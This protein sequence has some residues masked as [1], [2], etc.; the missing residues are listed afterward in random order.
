MHAG[1]PYDA[2]GV[3]TAIV[4][5]P[6]APSLGAIYKLVEV[7][8]RRDAR[9]PVGKRSPAKPSYGGAKQVYRFRH[10]DGTLREDIVGRAEAGAETPEVLAG[11]AL[12]VPVM[13]RGKLVRDLP[14][15]HTATE[16]ARQRAERA[17]VSLPPGL[18]SLEDT[19]GGGLPV[20]YSEALKALTPREP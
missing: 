11:E 1:A 8:D 13:R 4:L 20:S 17:L 12:L 2:F 19:V 10:A 16:M 5:T 7:G 14:D 9:V 3:G 18:R 6:D 15:L